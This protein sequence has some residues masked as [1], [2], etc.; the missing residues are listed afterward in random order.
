VTHEIDAVAEPVRIGQR[1]LDAV[2]RHLPRT[3]RLPRPGLR[4]Q[5]Q[6]LLQ[7]VGRLLVELI[8]RDVSDSESHGKS[9]SKL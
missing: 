6:P 2:D 7:R 1:R 8:T 5:P 9:Q 4:P 3:H